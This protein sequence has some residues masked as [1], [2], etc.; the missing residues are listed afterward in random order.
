M[1]GKCSEATFRRYVVYMTIARLVGT[2]VAQ[3]LFIP[4]AEMLSWIATKI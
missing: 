4:G 3:L 2:V 1:L